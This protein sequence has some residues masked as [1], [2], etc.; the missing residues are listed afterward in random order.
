MDSGFYKGDNINFEY[1]SERHGGKY[2]FQWYAHNT[3]EYF[4]LY[5]MEISDNGWNYVKRNQSDL[6]NAYNDKANYFCDNLTS[7]D[8]F[9]DTLDAIIDEYIADRN[10]K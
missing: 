4:D 5:L 3:K 1:I 8:A 2:F 6:M 9:Y 10:A 7:E